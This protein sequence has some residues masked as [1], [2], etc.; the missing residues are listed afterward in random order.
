VVNSRT[1]DHGGT[2]HHAV[3]TG[4][5]FGLSPALHATRSEVARALQDSG[6]GA[7]RRSRLQRG[8]VIAQIV[9]SQP[10]LIA[11]GVTIATMLAE[12]NP[13][14]PELLERVTRVSFR[15]LNQTGAASHRREAVDSLVPRIAAHPE[16][17]AVVPDPG[18]LDTRG[19][20]TTTSDSVAAQDREWTTLVIEGMAPGWL[21]LRDVPI[22]MG[23]DVS[24][25]DTALQDWPV[26]IGSN[27]ARRLWGDAHPIGRTLASPGRNAADSIRITVVGVYDATDPSIGTSE[28]SRVFTTHGK[29]WRRD[30]LLVRTRGSAEAF[31]PELRR[32]VREAAP[33][34]PVSRML[35]LE[36][37]WK[38]RLDET[39]GISAILGG[40]GALALLL[41]SLGLY[42]VIAL[43]VRQ[44][45]RE[46][47]IRITLGAKP[48]RVARMFLASGMRLGVVALLI[49][50]PASMVLLQLF[51]SQAELLG[52]KVNGWL[53]G[54][55]VA[56]ALMAVAAAATWIP[57]RR[58]SLVDPVNALR[59]E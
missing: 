20:T 2:E 36:Q 45:T 49:G 24:L 11:L 8:F 4:L 1:R 35:T 28:Q 38:A 10:L 51:L 17:V 26:V 50:L 21:A 40:A 18:W 30:A 7:S 31:M 56:V 54:A 42:G 47:G 58:A 5:V 33:G 59:S 12:Y 53:I 19:F 44:R 9:F 16:V 48:A 14:R 55:I 37:S 57:A 13:P 39:I 22:L 15:P 27:A 46:I 43:A 3:G 29:A 41:A 25:A 52:E 34:V 32:L 6:T 23:R